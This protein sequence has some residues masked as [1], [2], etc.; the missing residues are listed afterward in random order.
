LTE[1][2]ECLSKGPGQLQQQ[3]EAVYGNDSLPGQ[4]FSVDEQCK[5]IRGPL[6]FY[7]KGV[8]LEIKTDLKIGLIY[9]VCL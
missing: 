3:F 9:C 2:G 7:C 5:L 4:F 8:R 1:Q 6:S